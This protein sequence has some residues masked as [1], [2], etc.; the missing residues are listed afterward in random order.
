MEKNSKTWGT[1]NQLQRSPNF[2]P[3]PPLLP[4]PVTA[5]ETDGEANVVGAE[6][7]E[8]AVAADADEAVE[9]NANA[10]EMMVTVG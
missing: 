8:T 10:M 1:P 2:H 9:T 5:T 4:T 7:G 6:D 3:K